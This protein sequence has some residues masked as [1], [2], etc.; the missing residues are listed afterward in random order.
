[1]I[2][3]TI[4]QQPADMLGQ[5]ELGNMWIEAVAEGA[6]NRLASF[7]RPEIA[8]FLLLPKKYLTLENATALV[9]K[10]HDWFGDCANIQIEARQ[11]SVVGERL[12]I[13]YR[14]R[15]QRNGAWHVI[16]QQLYCTL[17]NGLVERLHLVCSGFQPL[18]D[19]APAAPVPF[20][21]SEPRDPE[22]HAL[23]DFRAVEYANGSTCALLTP[24]MRSKLREL[25]SGQVLEVRVDDPTAREDI[26]AWSRLTGNAILKMAAGEGQSLKFF[27]QKK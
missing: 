27:V 17:R 4:E 7:C 14:F 5:H 25:S 13:F 11:I 22:R 15:L 8:S 26:E 9:A 10:Y 18:D 3:L 1:M 16:E 20:Q 6:F 2:A 24:A 12:G 23:L 19:S 21:E